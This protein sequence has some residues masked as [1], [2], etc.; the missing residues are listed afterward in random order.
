MKRVKIVFSVLVFITIIP[1][2]LLAQPYSNSPSPHVIIPEVI[3]A[4]AS[5]GGTWI[6]SIQ[7]IIRDAGDTDIYANFHTATETR[8][9]FT[10]WQWVDQFELRKHNNILSYIQALDGTG[11]SYF[12][13]VGALSIFTNNMERRIYASARTYNG[14]FSKTIPGLNWGE[15]ANTCSA[16]RE[17]VVPNLQ[18]TNAY[19]CA[20]AVYNE[21][22]EFL[23]IN[24]ALVDEDANIIGSDWV[25]II[26]GYRYL[27][28]NPFVKA[29]VTGTNYTNCVLYMIGWN[30]NGRVMAIGATVFNGTN[31]PAC[32]IA[33][34]YDY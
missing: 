21:W 28:F 2:S 20:V 30:G 23:E 29:G 8:G 15:P 9:P 4:E 3:W 22:P 10:L 19:R 12:N 1:M 16:A 14:G 17:L 6:T 18:Q 5:G 26:D 33:Y 31:D 13:K 11:Y 32:H 24:F 34:Q 25:E 27:A 7:V